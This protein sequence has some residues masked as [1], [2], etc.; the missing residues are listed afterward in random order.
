MLNK[1]DTIAAIST[2]LGEGGIGIVRLSGKKALTIADK[3]FKGRN[4]ATPSKLPSYTIHYGHIIRNK[5]ILDEVILSIMRKPKSYTREDVVEINCHGGILPL[6]KTLEAVLECG[7]RLAEPGEFTKRAFLNGRIDL[8]QAEAVINIVEAKTELALKSAISQLKGAFS[9][10]VQ[11]LKD[12]TL[13]LLTLFEAELDFPEEDIEKTKRNKLIERIK[14]I[15]S[16]TD[17]LLRQSREGEILR[18]GLLVLLIGKANVGKS[19]FLNRLVGKERAIVTHIPGTTRDIIEEWINIEGIPVKIVDTAGF[20]KIENIIDK[21]AQEKV[22]EKLAD[23]NLVLFM[24]D[25]TKSLS[26]QDKEIAK[27]IK[28]KKMLCLINKVD[29]PEK[30]SKNKLKSLIGNKK[31]LEISA[32]KGKG[33]NAIKKFIRDSVFAGGVSAGESTIMVN[34]RSRESLKDAYN[35]LLKGFDAITEGLSEEFIAVDL[36]ESLNSFKKILGETLEEDILDR[37]FQKFCIGK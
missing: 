18:D 21:K 37:I 23:A 3:L 10:K 35:G 16:E 30:I 4:G 1:S 31:V 25:G 34:A 20:K 36:K 8:T 24:V 7:A 9:K 19:T 15:T 17:K 2:P 22:E 11:E 29:L 13:E 32:L 28:D 26:S 27:I 12:E 33:I 5:E 6:R 14:R